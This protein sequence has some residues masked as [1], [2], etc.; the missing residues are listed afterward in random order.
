MAWGTSLSWNYSEVRH[1]MRRSSRQAAEDLNVVA[2]RRHGGERRLGIH[3]P[4]VEL[5]REAVA[6][7]R[8][9]GAG[10]KVHTRQRITLFLAKG[11]QRYLIGPASTDARATTQYGRTTISAAEALGQT[12][13]SI[14]SNTDTTTYPGTTVTMTNGDIVGIELD[15][16]TIYWT[17][18]S[19]TPAATMTIAVALTA[20]AACREL[21][22]V[23][24][25][26]APSASRCSSYAVLRDENYHRHTAFVYLDVQSYDALPDKT[27]DGDPTAILVEPLRLNTAIT[28]DCSRTT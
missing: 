25:E 11:Q 16:G 7:Q 22:V 26:R 3:A 20:R 23:V 6:G 5:H 14:T 15:D 17:T 21:R 28:L 4:A 18:I 13:I 12:V 27:G 9:H 2:A 1:R 10:L 19:G 8:G 24:H